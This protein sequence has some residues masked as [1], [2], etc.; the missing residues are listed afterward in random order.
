M[1]REPAAAA[2]SRLATRALGVFRGRDAVA[3]GVSRDDLARLR[4]IEVIN[5]VL[6]DTYRLT[7]APRTRQQGLRAALLWAG[8]AAAATG[9][10]A[11]EVYGLEGVRA[12]KPEIAL[13]RE[14]R[15]RSADVIVCHGERA[16]FMVRRV[17]GIRV[18]GPEFTLLRLASSLD[19]V[20]L[21]IAFEDARRRRLTSMA[22]LRAY[23][24]RFG[25]SGRPGVATLRRLLHELDPQ[26]P[27]RS[28]LEVMTRRL[29]VAHAVT[30]FVREFPLEW[31]GRTY[32]C[33]FAFERERTILETNGRR[34]HDD[35]TDYESNHEKWSVPGRHGF[36]IVFATWDKVTRRPAELLSEL[37][38]APTA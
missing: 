35:P 16:A 7:G 34:W 13:P 23:L 6:P 17:N 9:R 19:D 15:G 24:A 29:L 14:V 26:H 1:P 38:S 2:V 12:D 30:G 10:S 20:A 37:A 4:R 22:S 11:A 36:R 33:D 25:R 21:E 8:D 28:T 32:R 5:R 3:L 27:A 18:T 31:H